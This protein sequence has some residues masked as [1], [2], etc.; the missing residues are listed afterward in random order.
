MDKLRA[1]IYDVER[2]MTARNTSEEDISI[3]RFKFADYSLFWFPSFVSP[4]R[5]K[6][7]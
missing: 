6:A 7:L 1:T 4:I 3:I 5:H 2:E